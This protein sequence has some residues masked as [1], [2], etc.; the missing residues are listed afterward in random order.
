MQIS[1]SKKCFIV[2]HID[3][4]TIWNLCVKTSDDRSKWVC[5]IKKSLGQRCDLD[6]SKIEIIKRRIVKQPV[7]IIPVPSPMCNEKW[8]YSSHGDDWQCECQ[9]G[10]S[11][12]P[13]NLPDYKKIPETFNRTLFSFFES[14]KDENG[15]PF[16]IIYENHMLK[17][18]GMM[19]SLVTWELIKYELYEIQFHTHSEHTIKNE[20]FDMEVQFYYNAITPGYLRKT[21]AVAVLFK[22][23]P[24]STNLFFDK[25]INILDL[26]DK[27]EKE[28]NLIKPLNLK[29]LFMLDNNDSYEGFSYYTY[30]GSLTSPNCQ[31]KIFFKFRGNYLVCNYKS[32]AYFIHYYPIF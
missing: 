24:G 29:H 11:Q 15:K 22:I 20:V 21:A 31:G 30:E 13:I 32:N 19:G 3:N 2:K 18:K 1:I 10:L 16:K 12:S 14:D 5:A 17:I 27:F 6:Q 8:D 26:P 9:E 23:V 28:K 4:K 7:I 25:T